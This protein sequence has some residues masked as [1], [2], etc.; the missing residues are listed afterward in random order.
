MIQSIGFKRLATLAVLFG[1]AL[2]LG[3][4]NFY[5]LQPESLTA[6]TKLASLTSENSALSGEIEIMQSSMERFVGQK[7]LFEKITNKGIFNEQSRVLARE[8]FTVMQKLSRLLAAKYEIRP[9]T[10]VPAGLSVEGGESDTYGILRSPI[11]ITLSALDDLDIY[12]FVY[13]LNYSF[14]GHI[15]IKNLYIER[16]KSVS[17][18]TL[19]MIGG[20]D[21]PEL[22]AAKMDVDWSTI[23]NTAS[24]PVP[25]GPAVEGAQP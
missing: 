22:V 9:A 17:P 2:A 4:L 13:Y 18:R 20:G 16:N 21:P 1:A 7:A 25:A 12:R 19:K 8:R 5:W 23:V 14:P 3:F 11:S 24:V 6:K 15:T 10:L